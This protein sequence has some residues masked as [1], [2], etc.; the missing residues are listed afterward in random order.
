MSN[1]SISIGGR[2]NGQDARS[3]RHVVSSNG[4]VRFTLTRQWAHWLGIAAISLLPA[5]SGCTQEAAARESAA[6]QPGM[7]ML[8]LG[9][10]GMDPTIL[11]RLME[12]GRMPNFKAL[13]ERGG[14]KSLATSM[15]P[16]SPV[17]WSNFIS[18]SH[19]GTHQIYD[20]VH[21]VPN[22][23]A[24]PG[25]VRPFQSISEVRPAEKTLMTGLLGEHWDIGPWRIPLAGATTQLLRR[26]PEFWDTLVAAGVQT[27]IYRLPANFPPPTK[28]PG[29]GRLQCICGMGTPDAHGGPG[30]FTF[31]GPDPGREVAGGEFVQLQVRDNHAVADLPG[32]PNFLARPIGEEPLPEMFVRFELDRDP[33]RDVVRIQQGE[34]VVVLGSGEW[35]DWIPIAYETGFPASSLVNSVFPTKLPAMVRLYVQQVHPELRVY[36]SPPNIDPR[37]Q[38]NPIS[39]PVSFG[40]DVARRSGRFYTTGIPEDTKALRE[41]ALNEDE[42]LQMVDLL[43]DERI[44]Q[45]R[46]ALA[47]FDRGF[48]FYYFGHIDQ[49]CH[50]FWRDTDPQHPGLKPGEAERYGGLIERIYVEMDALLGEALQVI[51]DNDVLIAMSDHGFS[52]FRRGFNLNTWLEQER[53][54][55]LKST[56]PRARALPIPLMNVNFSRTR[57]YALGIN[58]LYVN[59][60]G[61]ERE[62]IVKP[63]DKRALL[64]DIAAKLLEVRDADGTA[65]VSKVYIVEDEYPNADMSVAPDILVGYAANYRGSWS[66][67]LGGHPAQLIEDN[68]DRWSGDHCIAAHIVP[69]V[70]LSNRKIALD[71]PALTDLAPSILKMFG[72]GTPEGM[73]GR[74][75]VFTQ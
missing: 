15:P 63:E 47:R 4:Q 67:A 75:G 72:V 8:V 26:G 66:T 39:T 70:L 74:N 42:F 21:R 28:E 25:G 20:F 57:A 56:T 41:G 61:R 7:K 22:D 52:G 50:I 19:P 36:A 71:D 3:T 32:P 12:A 11:Q 29:S 2:R 34:Q 27:T 30:L 31:F 46:D 62:G 65:V 60:Q 40:D 58:C 9:I 68:L 23:P 18:G 17:A 1:A 38:L 35:S 59:L 69:G 10:D 5:M 37:A 13:A 45:Y 44:A 16:Q 49:L 64:N 73:H 24:W 54:L 55:S 48:L 14:F 33:E 53:F 43:I 51:D 6:R